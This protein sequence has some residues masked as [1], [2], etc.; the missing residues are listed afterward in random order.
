MN[1]IRIKNN[2]VIDPRGLYLLGASTKK[3]DETKIGQFGSG[4]K[5]AIAYL[6]RNDFELVIMAGEKE[7]KITTE[8]ERFREQDFKVVVIDGQKTSITTEMGKDWQLWQA[9][10]E[11]YCNALDEGGCTMDFV[12]EIEPKENETHFYIQN[13]TEVKKFIADFDDYFATNKKVLFE[14]AEGRILE[15]T[16]NNANVYRRGIKCHISNK[17]SVFDYDFKNI[18]IDENRLVKYSWE[19][20]KKIWSLIYQ[21]DNEEVIKQALHQCQSHE[22]IEG[23]VS[24]F[25]TLST[26]NASETFVK[27]LKEINLA[28]RG[29]AGLLKADEV[30]NHVILPTEVFKSVR[31]IIGDEN[32]GDNFKVTKKGAMFRVI[33]QESLLHNETLKKALYFLKECSFEVEYDIKL[34][35]FDDKEILGAAYEETILLSELCLDKGVNEIVNTILEEFIHIK[36]KVADETRAFQTAMLTEFVSYMKMKNAFA[37]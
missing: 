20:G 33:E 5:Y 21:C 34:V 15:S 36:Y 29:Y 31:G 28:P 10:R 2:G 3:N 17:Q 37:L 18:D 13:K 12:Q 8:A 19:I 22:L 27:V 11:I 23:N 25:V 24:E 4:N 26:A 1:Y 6:L 30:H 35:I 7:V 32:V 16:G 9:I 14:C